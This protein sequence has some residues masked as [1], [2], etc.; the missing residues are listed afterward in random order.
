M[1]PPNYASIKTRSLQRRF[2][3]ETMVLDKKSPLF[4]GVTKAL[5]AV[6]PVAH[7]TS[8]KLPLMT[9]KML[10]IAVLHATE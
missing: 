6:R 9:S 10:F 8:N 7:P 5:P 4:L 3:N 1:H 2:A